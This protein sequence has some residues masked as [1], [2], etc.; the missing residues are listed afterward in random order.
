MEKNFVL[1]KLADAIN[2]SKGDDGRNQYLI[3]RLRNNKEIINS[4]RLY[5]E[6]IL[7]LKIS[8]IE[9]DTVRIKQ[10]ISKK[11]KTIF[12]NPKMIKCHTCKKEINLDEKSSRYEN[13]WYH[14]QFA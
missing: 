7:D 14:E 10:T 3:E 1:S 2:Q 11:D 5:L 6:K 9:Y 4:D 13:N 12:L 8:H